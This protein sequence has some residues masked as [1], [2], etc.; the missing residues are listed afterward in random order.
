M[1][2]EPE[3]DVI[4]VDVA[5]LARWWKRDRATILAVCVVS[6]GLIMALLWS[7]PPPVT[8]S[9]T[10][11]PPMSTSSSGIVV[12]GTSLLG[13]DVF[14]ATDN[15]QRLLPELI[16]LPRV[17]ARASAR[18]VTDESG[19]RYAR[20]NDA[21][22]MA[23]TDSAT[24]QDRIQREMERKLSVNV[25]P[26]TDIV[27]VRLRGDDPVLT[28]T[29]LS[30]LLE[31]TDELLVLRWRESAKE[32]AVWWEGQLSRLRDSLSVADKALEMFLL[33]NRQMAGAPSLQMHL[34][35]L[36]R[37]QEHWKIA[38]QEAK[39]VLE[40]ERIRMIRRIP[41]LVILDPPRAPSETLGMRRWRWTLWGCLAGLSIGLLW[42]TIRRTYVGDAQVAA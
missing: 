3:S 35:A 42:S 41:A 19:V 15:V 21:I 11:L 18:P 33:E 32:K 37:A 13:R 8:V 38:V 12:S 6:S 20:W 29:Y 22:G 4:L 31:A 27:R 9:A 40:Q 36:R 17:I 25:D 16:R 24:A 39:V 1:T 30:H 14:N 26:K 34:A 7:V 28:A 10:L 2:L 23:N 5:D